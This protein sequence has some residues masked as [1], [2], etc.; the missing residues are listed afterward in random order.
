MPARSASSC[1]PAARV[2]SPHLAQLDQ[3]VAF[4]DGAIVG[5]ATLAGNPVLLAAQEGAFLGGAIG[6]VHGAKLMGLIDRARDEKPAA[7]LLLFD[8]GGVR[9]HEANAGLIAVSELIRAVLRARLDGV[10][11]IGLIGGAGGCFGGTGLIARCCDVL[12]MSEEGRLGMSGPEVIETARGVDEFDSR[13]RALIWRVTGG[14]HRYLLGEVDRLVE[15]DVRCFREAAIDALGV[16]GRLVDGRS[17]TRAR[18]AAAT[19]GALRPLRRCAGNL[20]KARGTSAGAGLAAAGRAIRRDGGSAQERVMK[21]SQLLQALFGDTWQA[22]V[23]TE[24][25][26]TG[27]GRAGDDT[28]QVIGTDNATEVG[29]ELALAMAG[30]VLGTVRSQPRRPILFLLDTQGQRLRRRDEL[31]GL[32]GY[33][34]HLAKCVEIARSRGHRI[35]SLVYGQA[36]SGGYLTTGMMADAC[37]ALADAEIK[38]M[39]LPAMSR[40]TKIPQERLEALAAQSPVFSPGVQ[41][42][43]RMGHL[44][45]IWRDD[46]PGACDRRWRSRRR[47]PLLTPQTCAW[48]HGLKRG[49]RTSAQLVA[50]RV[51]SH[52]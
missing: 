27:T 17:R 21:R 43:H 8:S 12:V 36:V 39:N 51:R 16:D 42:Y 1:R 25:F 10:K 4:D 11:F 52:A 41:N 20:A 38:V 37:Y 34:A 40:I 44:S 50:E 3:P 48:S 26:F 28:I 5:A 18:A 33:M 32:N 15:D 30:A 22:E 29:V 46:L 31:L 24:S 35:L 45:E 23:D 19:L 49:G 6:E 47:Y 13:D 14:K 9:L 2:T 7:V